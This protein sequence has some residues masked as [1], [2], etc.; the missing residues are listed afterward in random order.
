MRLRDTSRFFVA[1]AL[2]L[3]VSLTD[4]P[5][6]AQLSEEDPPDISAALPGAPPFPS[7][8]RK[9]LGLEL[10]SRPATY[11][12]RTHNF[13]AD[14]SPTFTNRLLLEASPYLQQHAHNPVN[15]YPWGD[16]AFETARRLDRAVLVSIG[17]ST[18]H[19]CHVMEEESFDDVA[20]ATYLNQRFIAIKVDREAR[21]D[22]DAIYMA[23]VHAMGQRGGWPLN[24]WMTPDR[25]PFFGGTYFPREAQGGSR[26][27][28]MALET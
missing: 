28:R 10:A 21:P 4:A 14:G 19:W 9:R 24:V 27:A 7:A 13:R 17:Y 11:E 12:P 2:G 1:A 22:V 25:K 15:W 26:L 18:C 5:A 3:A 20:T 6:A 8:T 16:E 23:A